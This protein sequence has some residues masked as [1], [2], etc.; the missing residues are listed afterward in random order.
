MYAIRIVEYIRIVEQKEYNFNN[1]RKKKK[2][3]RFFGLLFGKFLYAGNL[4]L[5][6]TSL[7]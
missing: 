1:L 5:G 3:C 7:F 6:V 4:L 2:P